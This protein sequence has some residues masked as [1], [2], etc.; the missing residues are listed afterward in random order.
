M[1]HLVAVRYIV[2]PQRGENLTAEVCA[3]GIASDSLVMWPW[4]FQIQ[5]QR[6]RHSVVRSCSYTIQCTSCRSGH[7]SYFVCK[8][9]NG[10]F[11]LVDT[12]SEYARKWKKISA[13]IR[14]YLLQN[15][16]DHNIKEIIQV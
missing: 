9:A 12:V 1:Y 14:E 15:T 10:T 7:L 4:L 11:A 8:Q 5:A 6:F 16:T 2:H 3:S 13:E